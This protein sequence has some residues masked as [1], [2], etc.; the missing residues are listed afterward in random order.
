MRRRG[1]SDPLIQICIAPYFAS[2][3]IIWGSV[4]AYH[5]LTNFK[6]SLFSDFGMEPCIWLS[7]KA[8]SKLA[9][10]CCRKICYPQFVILKYFSVTRMW[11]E[12][13]TTGLVPCFLKKCSASCKY[14]D[15]LNFEKNSSHWSFKSHHNVFCLFL[16]SVCDSQIP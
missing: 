11:F 16:C 14:L 4:T 8:S 5:F 9:F 3:K 7:S 13:F 12:L 15:Y 2:V 6:M 1:F 10:P